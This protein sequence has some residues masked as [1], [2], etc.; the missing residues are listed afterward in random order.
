MKSKYPDDGYY[1]FIGAYNADYHY[2]TIIVNKD[3]ETFKFQF[4]DQIVG[5]MEYQENNLE[6]VK[7]LQNIRLYRSN[8]PMQLELYQLRNKKK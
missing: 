2:F 1:A 4:I 8:F 6:N 5:V 7:L 3:N